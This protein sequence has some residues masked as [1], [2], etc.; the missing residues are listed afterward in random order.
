MENLQQLLF[1]EIKARIRPNISMV[2][3][4]ASLLN[5]SNDSA[6]RRIRGEKLITL[7]EIQKLA[8]HFK[9]SI[10]KILNLSSDTGTFSGK[11]ITADNFDF[12]KYL[13]QMTTDLEFI[14][15]FKQKEIIFF[16]KDIP[17]FHY[18]TYPELA[19]FKYFFWMKTILQFSQFNNTPFSFDIL[20][21]TMIDDGMK[22]IKSYNV[23]P[24][25]EI[26]SIENI[27]TTLRQIEFY[28][29]TFQFKHQEEL[30]L[31][32]DKLHEMTDHICHQAETGKKFMPNQNHEL[33]TGTY[34]L[35]VNDF[36][37]GDNSNIVTV[38]NNK[39][40][41]LVHSHINYIVV[42]DERLTSYQYAFIQ[43]IIKKS[44]LISDVGEKYRTR[45]FHLIHD[46]I[47]QCREGRMQ[48]IGKL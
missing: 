14:N 37:I 13:G 32:Y 27:N 47:E 33:L 42:N 15:S 24:S 16:S 9:I 3:E 46:K 17:S 35:Y 30:N 22:V 41:F 8:A 10:D 4:I 25:V 40:S 5:I 38:D 39:L 44:I 29:E 18:F 45:F 34:K 21:K 48:T 23:I 11:Y 1:T 12:A 43:N 31:I 19:A 2:D 6:Y 36:I 28:K 7:E 20:L 26:M